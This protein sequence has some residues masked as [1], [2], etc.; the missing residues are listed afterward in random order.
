MEKYFENGKK[1]I[2][3]ESYKTS[4]AEYQGNISSKSIGAVITQMNSNVEEIINKNR[5][6][7][8]SVIR[9]VL[10]Q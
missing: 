3:A 8:K 6:V 5:E 2:S 9:S 4:L 1:R 10:D 7:L